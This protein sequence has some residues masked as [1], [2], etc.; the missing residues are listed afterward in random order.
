M[1]ADICNSDE[2]SNDESEGD[3]MTSVDYDTIIE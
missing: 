2:D 3:G 1:H